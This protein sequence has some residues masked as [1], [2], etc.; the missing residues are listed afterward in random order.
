MTLPWT[1]RGGAS[2]NIATVR[3]V[4][5]DSRGLITTNFSDG[6]GRLVES[7]SS[8]G[9]VRFHHELRPGSS[10]PNGTGALLLDRT[11][12]ESPLGITNEIIHDARRRPIYSVDTH[13]VTNATSYCECGSPSQV[14]AALGLTGLARTTSFDY[15]NQGRLWR[16]TLPAGS[17]LTN[18]YDVSGRLVVLQDPFGYVTNVYD[19]LNRIVARYGAAGLVLSNR[20]DAGDRIVVQ[21]D[22]AGVTITNSFDGLGRLRTLHRAGGTNPILAYGYT[23]GIAAPTAETNAVGSIRSLQFDAG[24]RLTTEV[25]VGLWTNSFAYLPAGDLKHL[26]DGRGNRTEWKYDA[27]GRVREKWYQ[28]QTNADLVYGYDAVGRL[29]NRFSR[30]DNPGT[31]GYNTV[32]AYDRIGNLTNVT[33]P[34]YSGNVARAYG[35]DALGRLTNM[36]D[37]VGTTT[38]SYALG[39]GGVEV[40][41]EDGPW[42]SDTVTVTNRHGLRSH[43]VIGQPSGTFAT[44][45]GWDA[46]RRM[47]NVTAGGQGFGYTYL[48]AGGQIARVSLPGGS[49]ITNTF[50]SLGRHT[51]TA[52][53]TSGGTNLNLHGYAY[54]AADRRTWISRTN[55]ANTGW[56]GYASFGYDAAGQLVR[57]QTTNA[58]GTEVTSERFGYAYDASQNLRWRTNNTSVTGFT[59]NGLNQ[60]SSLNA[61]TRTHD[62]RGNLIS[63]VQS[64]ETLL[65]S[66]DDENQL[67]SVRVDPASSPAFQPWRIDFVYDGL[68]RL[69]R[70]LQFTWNGS[71]WTSQG[72][73]RYLY[74]GMLIVQERNSSNTP[75]VHYSRG[76]DLSGTIHGAGG[77]GG[78]LMRSHGYSAGNWSSHNAYHSDANG[79]VTALVNSSGVLQASYK[80]NPYGG[81]ISSSGT[82]AT[83]NTMRFS[84]KPAIFSSGGAWGFYYYGYRFYDPVNQR[85]LN[86][87]PLGEAG[88]FALYGFIRNNP[89]SAVDPLG[90]TWFDG[91]AQGLVGVA[92]GVAIGA[93][94]VATLPASVAVGVAIGATAFGG[95]LMGQNAFEFATGEEAY[96]GR[97]LSSDERETCGGRLVVD[98]ATIGLGR[99]KWFRRGAEKDGE[100]LRLPPRQRWNA[101]R[102][103]LTVSPERWK[104][105]AN[106]PPGD[107]GLN[108]RDI[109]PLHYW[110]G[111]NP[112]WGSGASPGLR[113]VWPFT[114][115]AS[116]VLEMQK[117]NLR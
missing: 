40:V 112:T 27:F 7:R 3:V 66:W 117:Q 29:T 99:C 49:T 48:G 38:Y 100:W 108:V 70:T 81:L 16:T 14:T 107:R 91:I 42:A 57:A 72:E 52:L 50:D 47:T 25:Q 105:V 109:S 31:N 63:N 104:E 64:G 53:R 33:S 60:L 73:V 21:T 44:T 10:Y 71:A 110:T 94:V 113:F 22:A 55:S 74:D 18:Y 59:N 98:V 83:A 75:Q 32:Y 20:F 54:D 34:A 101:D 115:G 116:G 68:R 46:A 11:L 13:G 6:L 97:T 93:V 114:V 96:T 26:D 15:D 61:T 65:Y 56:N 4:A 37:A 1:Y 80:Y 28:G 79:N 87:D 12:I 62:R 24:Q 9:T 86:R 43:L 78:L 17:I 36:V 102:D 92:A 106:L 76:L 41:T 5:T 85:W 8:S 2:S 19:N 23:V 95:F 30:T 35:Y 90:L 84:S 111:D 89:V 51:L 103:K 67:T 39:T 77:I 82:L 45:Y 69:R 58:A 88:G